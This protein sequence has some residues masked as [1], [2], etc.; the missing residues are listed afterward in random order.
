MRNDILIIRRDDIAGKHKAEHEP[1]EYTKY[2]VTPRQDFQQCYVAF[3]EIPP[4]KSNYPYHYHTQNTEVFYILDGQGVLETPDGNR[5]ISAGDVI[6][7]PPSEQ[8]AHRIL[9]TSET[10][11]LT[12]LDF[13]T[14]HSPEILHYP[15][16]GKTGVI[17]HNQPS[18]FFKDNAE[19]D[20]YDGE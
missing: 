16:S 8:S 17:T 12:Y 13:D 4:G 19:V 1:Y 14:T 20:Y 5:D 10:E 9:N 11:T 7:C 18:V 6:V 2:E 3:Y 15:H